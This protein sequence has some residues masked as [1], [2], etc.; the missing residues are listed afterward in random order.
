MIE[1]MNDRG[2]AYVK[3]LYMQIPGYVRDFSAIGCRIDFVL[4]KTFPASEGDIMN[5]TLIPDERFGI[6]AVILKTELRWKSEPDVYQS[7]GVHIVG[8]DSPQME[9]DYRKIVKLFS[10]T[11]EKNEA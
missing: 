2:K 6:P 11:N 3:V 1:R 8:F 5:L 10:D 4:N 9:K 7:T